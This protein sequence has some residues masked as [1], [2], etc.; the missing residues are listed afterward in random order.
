MDGCAPAAMPVCKRVSA[1]IQRH[2]RAV[3]GPRTKVRKVDLIPGVELRVDPD[4]R[5]LR[6]AVVKS[7][8]DFSIIRMA[9]PRSDHGFTTQDTKDTKAGRTPGRPPL[10]GCYPR[11]RPASVD[12]ALVIFGSS[13]PFR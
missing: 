10:A 8:M 11:C 7:T 9:R 1:C 3:V 12:E 6:A 13:N 4:L 5:A 2:Q